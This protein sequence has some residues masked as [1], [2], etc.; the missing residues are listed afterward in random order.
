MV[1]LAVAYINSEKYAEADAIL[2]R[3]V[4]ETQTTN[5]DIY[6]LQA[7]SFYNNEKYAEAIAPLKR[8]MEL[9]PEGEAQWLQMLMAAYS[10]TGQE[11]EALALAEQIVAKKPDDKTALVNLAVMYTNADQPDK[12][13]ALLDEARKRGLM[14]QPADYERIYGAY[15][16]LEREAEAAAVIEDGLAKGVLPANGRYYMMIAQAHYFSD[17][18]PGAIAAG[19]KAAPL[20][21][22]GAPAL[23]L[24]QMYDQ[25]DRNGEAKAAARMA[26]DKGL[27]KPGDAWMVIARSEYYSDNPAGAATAYREAMKDPATRE[28]AQKALAQISR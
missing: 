1:N 18:I 7:A 27:K 13:L 4:T 12:A 20:A 21:E 24:A 11:P 22:D 6:G 25:E 8:A 2:A 3:L 10:E 16:N 19:Q 28:Q 17:N 15:Y 5:P 14:D 23:F 26:L 9:K